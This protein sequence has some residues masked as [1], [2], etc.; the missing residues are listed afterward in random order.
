VLESYDVS[1]CASFCD[2]TDLCTAFNLYIERDPSLNPTSG[3]TNATYCPNPSSV[4]NYK[5]SLWGSSI[6]ASSATNYGDYQEQ[7]QVVIAASN[8]YDKTNN[9]TPAT[10]PGWESPHK[11]S[12]GAISSGGSYHIGSSFYPGPFDPSVCAIYAQAQTNKNKQ[13]AQQSG[14]SSYVSVEDCSPF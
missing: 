6:D 1:G 2:Q 14:A 4:T 3:E 7:F 12:G 8:G 13:V 9:T 11:C 5:C 10:Q